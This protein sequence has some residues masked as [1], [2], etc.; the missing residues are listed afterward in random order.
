MVER[1]DNELVGALREEA[2]RE[3]YIKEMV[4]GLSDGIKKS[5]HRFSVYKPVESEHIE[6]RPKQGVDSYIYGVGL[7]PDNGDYLMAHGFKDGFLKEKNRFSQK[8][9]SEL[10]D[11]KKY[12]LARYIGYNS[13]LIKYLYDDRG[14]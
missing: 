5:M 12:F 3:K 8:T 6:I 14:S 7:D 4:S 2:K 13:F 11:G 9:I 1:M 10:S